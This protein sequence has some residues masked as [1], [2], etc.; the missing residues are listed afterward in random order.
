MKFRRAILLI[1]GLLCV[2]SAAVAFQ[3]EFREYGGERPL[4]LPPDA[5]Q[6]AEFVFGRL[7]YP[8]AG[9]G[10]FRGGFG[11]DWRQGGRTNWTNDYPAADRHLMVAL[12]RLTS[13]QVRSVEQPVNLEDGDDV[14]NWPFLFAGRTTAIDLTDEMV[15]KLRDY[16]DRGGFLICDDMWGR[17][18]QEY[19]TELVEKLY[20]NRE[21]TEL[22]NN[23]V[24]M[25]TVFN[26]NDRYQI[27]GQW[28]RFTG[29]PLDG[30]SYDPHW[31]GVF[32]DK[33]HMVM[34]TW[35]NSDTGDSWEWADD[36]T[37]PEHYSALGFRI[38]IN[39]IAYA[40]TH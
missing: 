11:R 36:P 27:I 24:V 29:Q 35:F 12:R 2:L 25:H 4:P 6:P 17:R 38:V 20:P 5:L 34:A 16:L 32:D 26:L 28:G 19:V 1:A 33:G 18:E 40:L 30:V 37:Y 31:K 13:L 22:G 14:F 23:D 15:V 8:S 7:M 21:L 3:R 39:H 10:G 9:G